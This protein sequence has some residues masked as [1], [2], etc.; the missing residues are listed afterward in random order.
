MTDTRSLT[1]TLPLSRPDDAAVQLFL[2]GFRQMGANGVDD[3][4]VA[5]AFVTAFGKNFRR[6]LILLRTLMLDLSRAAGRPMQIAPWCCCRM[7]ASEGAMVAVLSRALAN[8]PAAGL[9]LADMLSVRDAT[10]ALATATALAAAFAD[11]G[12]PIEG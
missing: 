5:H 8:P 3:A 1:H 10:P 2:F 11:L 12:M 6:P 9:L 4:S 7:T